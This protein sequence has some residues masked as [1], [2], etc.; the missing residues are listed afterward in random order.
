MTLLHI[1]KWLLENGGDWAKLDAEYGI[2][3]KHHPEYPLT[4]LVYSQ[5]DSPKMHPMVQECRGLVIGKHTYGIEAMCFNR[6][7]NLGEADEIT[8]KF[9]WSDFTSLEKLDGSLIIVFWNIYSG[10]WQIT[11]KGSFAEGEIQGG[12]PKWDDLVKSLIGDRLKGLEGAIQFT[13]IFELCSLYNKV[14]REYKEPKLVLLGM[15][16]GITEI[17]PLELDFE[18]PRQYHF[19]SLD[20][21]KEFI[22]CQESID[23][24]F[25]GLVVKDK[26]GLRL[27]IKSSTYVALHQLKGNDNLF[28]TKNLLPFIL[29]G[30]TEE[31]ITYFPE[32][33][34]KVDFLQ[35]ELD[36]MMSVLLQLWEDFSGL[37]SQKEF[38]LAIQGKTPLSGILFKCRQTGGDVKSLFRNS[39]DMILKNL[40]K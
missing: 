15:F 9:D 30:E 7:F 11:T 14:V 23:P 19:K 29:A 22:R 26:N 32:C 28:L 31:V 4:K 12:C 27:K 38:A 35:G 25:E 36:Y 33:K 37:E 5:I 6:F 13:F 39:G 10:D 21:V 8:S 17:E 2:T 24:T 18:R 3:A 16:D 20:E 40:E 34:E 1:Q